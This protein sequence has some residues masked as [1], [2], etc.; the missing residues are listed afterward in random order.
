MVEKV[1]CAGDVTK[2]DGVVRFLRTRDWIISK[3][4]ALGMMRNFIVVLN[5]RYLSH[6]SEPRQLLPCGWNADIGSAVSYR[7]KEVIKLA[8]ILR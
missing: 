7:L 1:G 3:L 2:R 6:H 4:H 5:G 8:V